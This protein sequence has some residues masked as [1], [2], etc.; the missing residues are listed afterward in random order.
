MSWWN[1]L[2]GS[3]EAE[4]DV[5]VKHVPEDAPA[6]KRLYKVKL[7][8]RAALTITIKTFMG[9]RWATG[10]L[11]QPNGRWVTFDPDRVA[12]KILDPALVPLIEERVK[13][14]RAIDRRLQGN[15][16]AEFK[17]EKGQR[18]VRA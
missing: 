3:V 8:E 18:W 2:G 5:Q 7:D 10:E 13:E 1:L 11:T 15:G 9:E 4:G 17:D 16:P 14:V 6:F 12:D